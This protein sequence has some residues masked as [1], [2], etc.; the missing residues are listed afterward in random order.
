MSWYER[1]TGEK[2]ET[3]GV[4]GKKLGKGEEIVVVFQEDEPRII[5][6]GDVRYAAILVKNNDRLMELRFKSRALARRLMRLQLSRGSLK[7]LKVRIR[8][9]TGE[10]DDTRWTVEVVE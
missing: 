7:D 5:E 8:R 3:V 1:L 9:P 4:E 2:P 10:G 6:V